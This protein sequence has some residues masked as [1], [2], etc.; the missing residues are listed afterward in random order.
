MT[1]FHITTSTAIP[2]HSSPR[3]RFNQA[4]PHLHHFVEATVEHTYHNYNHDKFSQIKNLN[5]IRYYLICNE[6]HKFV[7]SY[8]ISTIAYEMVP[9]LIF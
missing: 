4:L 2:T 6:K 3:W 9:D 8:K 1:H 5:H 7:I